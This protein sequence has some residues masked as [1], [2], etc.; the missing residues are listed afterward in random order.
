[1]GEAARAL[2]YS[3]RQ[4]H[5]WF[6]SYNKGGIE[7]LLAWHRVRSPRRR[8][9]AS[10]LEEA[11]GQAQDGPPPARE[12]R[13]QR[14]Q[15][16]FKKLR[17]SRQPKPSAEAAIFF[18]QGRS[19]W[20][21][22]PSTKLVSGSSTAH[23]LVRETLLSQGV[24]SQGVSSALQQHREALLQMDLS[25]VRGGDRTHNRR[26]LLWLPWLLCVPLPGHQQDGRWMPLWRYS[27]TNSPTPTLTI[28]C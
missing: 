11:Q 12:G 17:R 15:E 2:G 22:W 25:V 16:A 20:R 19:R 27:S 1:M 7:E 28:T 5:R 8:R 4:C 13:P 23:Q 24:S 21:F 14:E 18:A 9:S 3:W 26:E 10:A 6:A